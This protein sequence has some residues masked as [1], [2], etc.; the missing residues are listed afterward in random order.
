VSSNPGFYKYFT[1]SARSR[2]INNKNFGT[3]RNILNVPRNIAGGVLKENTCTSFSA[4]RSGCLRGQFLRRMFLRREELCFPS[5][6]VREP[7][8]LT[9]LKVRRAAEISLLNRYL[10]APKFLEHLQAVPKRKHCNFQ[11]PASCIFQHKFS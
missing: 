4:Q 10:S 7:V 1:H 11:R 5:E 3:P 2:G 6:I 8:F 9:S